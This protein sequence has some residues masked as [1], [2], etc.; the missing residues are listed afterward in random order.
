MAFANTHASMIAVGDTQLQ[1]YEAGSGDPVVL[2]SGWPKSAL[3]WER[4]ISL[5][6]PDYR[7]IAIEPPA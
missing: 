7:V 4:V 5:L 1:C 6:A 3:S 2:I